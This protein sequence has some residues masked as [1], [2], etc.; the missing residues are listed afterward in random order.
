MARFLKFYVFTVKE[1]L[2]VIQNVGHR[3]RRQV[4]AYL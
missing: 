4:A 2:I 1:A 3:G